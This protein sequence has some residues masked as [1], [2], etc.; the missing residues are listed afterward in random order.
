MFAI[1]REDAFD[2]KERL[3]LSE[4][5]RNYNHHKTQISMHNKMNN[6]IL[7]SFTNN[8]DSG[9]QILKFKESVVKELDI[10]HQ[11]ELRKEKDK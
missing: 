8:E 3:D 2:L 5:M 7:D 9:E 4:V 10:E 1:I 6:I 11:N